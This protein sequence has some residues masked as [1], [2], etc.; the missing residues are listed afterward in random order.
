MTVT[1]VLVV[2]DEPDVRSSVADILRDAGYQVAEAADGAEALDV[3]ARER[4]GAVLLDL[5]MPR[6]DGVT[7][8]DKL[9]DP[10]PI[11]VVS[12]RSPDDGERARLG[13]KVVAVL[14]KPVHPAV[15][16]ERLDSVL[17][18]RDGG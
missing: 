15:L 4:V 12:A 17:G 9:D 11:L 18:G 6:I 5:R 2:E 10:P 14:R 7:L 1:D 13:R 8:V 3:L 16:L